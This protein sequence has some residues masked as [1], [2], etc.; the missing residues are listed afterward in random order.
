MKMKTYIAVVLLS[1]SLLLVAGCTSLQS[2]A[3]NVE[4]PI[5]LDGEN[6]RAGILVKVNDTVP[7]S[8]K[9]AGE[10]RITIINRL[11]EEVFV[12]VTGF[13]CLGHDF[14]LFDNE[15]NETGWAGGG[16]AYAVFPDNT[17]H[18][19]RLHGSSRDE[20]GKV[21]TCGCCVAFITGKLALDD[22]DLK[23]WIGADAKVSIP[24]NGYLR[25]N[26]QHFYEI[27][28][29]PIEIVDGQQSPAGDVLKAAPE[30]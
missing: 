26:G 8:G 20:D 1:S 19:K 17:H 23:E 29:V 7:A 13:D 30:E 28:D 5:L 6:G 27:V 24:I 9:R 4:V 25:R 18:L 14:T 21:F 3:D 22:L 10:V 2:Q 12:A 15:G 16:G 11:E